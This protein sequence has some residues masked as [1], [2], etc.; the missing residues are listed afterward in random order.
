MATMAAPNGEAAMRPTRGSLRLVAGDAPHGGGVPTGQRSDSP[1][2]S[3]VAGGQLPRSGGAWRLS[4][5]G[6]LRRGPLAVRR[7]GCQR[8]SWLPPCA[9]RIR[10]MSGEGGG[11]ASQIYRGWRWLV[12]GRRSLEDYL[13]R[14]KCWKR[15]WSPEAAPNASLAV[16]GLGRPSAQVRTYLVA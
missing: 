4:M 1:C 11:R 15:I 12:F 10:S 5:C 2:R 9:W 16:C 14:T 3:F 7:R 8:Q 6:N 13:A